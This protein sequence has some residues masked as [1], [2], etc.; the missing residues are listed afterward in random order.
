MATNEFLPFA[1]AVGSNVLP[2][3]SY[4]TLAARTNGF[5]SGV[6]QSVHCNKVWRQS[7]FIAAMVAQF[8]A[9]RSGNNMLDDGNLAT[10]EASF[11]AGITQVAT[12]VMQSGNFAT[13]AALN[14]EIANRGN[15]VGAEGVTRGAQDSAEATARANADAAEAATRFAQDT[16]IQNA[17][18]TRDAAITA[19]LA[20]YAPL[21]SFGNLINMPGFLKLPSGLIFQWVQKNATNGTVFQLLPLTF[22]NRG[23]GVVVSYQAQVPPLTGTIGADFFDAS[24]LRIYNS[25]VGVAGAYNAVYALAW[26]F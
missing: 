11:I 2:Q 16:T 3:S 8:T 1:L 7:A 14:A 24:T 6:A 13:V 15:A 12:T 18:V 26:G 10:A 23:L 25:A 17:S 5:N 4:A 22:P 19:S 20:G 21:S 9:D